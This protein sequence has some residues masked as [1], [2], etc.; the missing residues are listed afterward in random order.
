MKN[1]N[2]SIDRLDGDIYENVNG[3]FIDMQSIVSVGEIITNA[4]RFGTPYPVYCR[5]MEKPIMVWVEKF[6]ET[7]SKNSN[8]VVFRRFDHEK[9][10]KLAEQKRL[11]FIEVWKHWKREN[12]VQNNN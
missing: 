4:D 2:E 5:L 8:G 9:Q 10:E 1:T 3:Q 12:E 11:E 7:D 6:F